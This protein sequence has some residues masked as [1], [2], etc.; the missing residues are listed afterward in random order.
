MAHINLLPWRAERRKLRQREFFMQLGAAGLIAVG[1]LFL[2]WFWM[3]MRIDNQNDRNAYMQDQ[4]K[5]VD[6]R[7]EKIK[8]LEKVRAQLLARKQII[9]QLQANRSQMVHLF[10][11]L[12]KTIPSSARLTSIKQNGDQMVLGG[13]AQSNASVAEYMRNIEASPWMGQAD[14]SKTENSHDASRMPYSFGL[15]VALSKPKDDSNAG[16]APASS[17]TGAAAAATTTAKPPVTTP[18]ATAPASAKPVTAPTKGGSK[19]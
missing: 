18:P 16:S 5:Q 14:L 6:A 7:L 1:V 3:D 17:N 15:T 10:D 13:V 11:E 9:E 2:W 12:V 19:Q 4:I 8:D